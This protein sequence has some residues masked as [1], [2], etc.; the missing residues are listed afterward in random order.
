MNMEVLKRKFN[1][2]NIVVKIK[3]VEKKSGY[4]K[5]R[6]KKE[7]KIIEEKQCLERKKK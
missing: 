7:K 2:F 6:V 5:I 4:V 3:E 1:R